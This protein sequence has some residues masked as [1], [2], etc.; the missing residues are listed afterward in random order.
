VISFGAAAPDPA[1][2][3]NDWRRR[4]RSAAASP[5]VLFVEQCFAAAENQR[6]CTGG[7]VLQNG[8]QVG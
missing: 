8:N 6:L 1:R 5:P 4:P 3:Q 2:R 7:L